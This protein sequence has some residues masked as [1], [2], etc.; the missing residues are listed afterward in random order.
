MDGK[1]GCGWKGAAP[2]DEITIKNDICPGCGAV[3]ELG[4]NH[5]ASPVYPKRRGR[6]RSGVISK[7]TIRSA[8]RKLTSGGGHSAPRGKCTAACRAA[9]SS[10]CNCVCNGTWHGTIVRL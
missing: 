3:G 8:I 7:R 4:D 5:I 2:A 1:N 6:R 9:T 10:E